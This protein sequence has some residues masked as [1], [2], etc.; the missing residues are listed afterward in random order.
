MTTALI[1]ALIAG[2]TGCRI[3]VAPAVRHH[4]AAAV[5]HYDA[6]AVRHAAPYYSATALA[7]KVE[8]PEKASLAR[9]NERLTEAL[10]EELKAKRSQVE[11]LESTKAAGAEHGSDAPAA[12]PAAPGK[13]AA[14][15][16]AN[17]V[18]C[19]SGEKA[20]GGFTLA[21]DADGR[22]SIAQRALIAEVVEDGSMPKGKSFSE[23]EKRL[24]ADW[25]VVE[26]EELKRAA[27]ASAS[28][29]G[30]KP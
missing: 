22:A 13:V 4:Q 6:H 14:L 24:V 5:I 8:D 11:R 30:G 20:Q 25:A 29:E 28:K 19:H 1:A 17:C 21:L 16:K 27:K 10:V 12:A 23:E 3:A 9:Q 18:K 26:R 15:L 2:G 7:Y